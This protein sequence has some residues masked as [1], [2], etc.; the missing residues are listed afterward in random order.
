MFVEVDRYDHNARCGQSLE[1]LV[2]AYRVE[3]Q[4]VVCQQDV[5]AEGHAHGKH[6]LETHAHERKHAQAIQHDQA[7]KSDQEV[8]ARETH[9]REVVLGVN[10]LVD[11]ND[12]DA[13]GQ[14]YDQA[15]ADDDASDQGVLATA[16]NAPVAANSLHF[17]QNGAF[18]V[19]VRYGSLGLYVGFSGVRGQF[20]SV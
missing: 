18:L 2:R 9:V 20:N 4:R 16:Q 15:D 19:V 13:R 10:V 14:I 8:N 12:G 7:H 5:A 17:F 11:L 1:A 3:L 6:L